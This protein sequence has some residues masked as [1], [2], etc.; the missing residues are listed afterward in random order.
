MTF[1]DYPPGSL[2]Y[3]RAQLQED[4][5]RL[6]QSAPFY[7]RWWIRRRHR[8]AWAVWERIDARTDEQLRRVWMLDYPEEKQ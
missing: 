3:H 1:D 5:E 4:W 7:L 2:G 8:K 6:I